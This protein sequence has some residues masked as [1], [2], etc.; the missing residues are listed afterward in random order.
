MAKG[1]Y[2]KALGHSAGHFAKGTGRPEGPRFGTT[3]CPRP[4]R[5]RLQSQATTPGDNPRREGNL[6]RMRTPWEGSCVRYDAAIAS[7][8]GLKE[9]GLG[10]LI[11]NKIISFCT[12]VP[13]PQYVVMWLWYYPGILA[14]RMRDMTSCGVA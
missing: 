14:Y 5:A 8:S 13:I 11:S 10:T 2:A 4:R 3:F 1:A 9:K 7:V 12:W 6:T